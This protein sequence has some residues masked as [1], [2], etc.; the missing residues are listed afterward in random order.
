MIEMGVEIEELLSGFPVLELHP[1]RDAAA[2]GVPAPRRAFGRGADPE[3]PAVEQDV[4][5]TAVHDHQMLAA[6][7][8]LLDVGR[9]V[10]SHVDLGVFGE[11]HLQIVDLRPVRLLEADDVGR[12]RTDHLQTGGAPRNPAVVAVGAGL[13]IAD[14]ERHQ[15]QVGLRSGGGQRLVV[16]RPQG[17]REAEKRNKKQ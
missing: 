2:H 17:Q 9:G 3:K 11:V 14:V 8:F 4:F 12:F 5:R 6:V 15:F 7:G 16:L 13:V 10:A 1:H